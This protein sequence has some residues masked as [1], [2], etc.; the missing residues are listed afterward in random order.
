MGRTIPS[1]KI[2]F[3]KRVLA[4]SEKEYKIT[5]A[6]NYNYVYEGDILVGVDST[7]SVV[8]QQMYERLEAEVTL[9]KLDQEDHPCSCTCLVDQMNLTL[10]GFPN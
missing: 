3:N 8:R 6:T 1:R 9:P 10:K 2:C 5:I 4:I 7:Y